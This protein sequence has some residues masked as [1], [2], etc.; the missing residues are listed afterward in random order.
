MSFICAIAFFVVVMAARAATLPNSKPGEIA[1]CFGM[2]VFAAMIFVLA[3]CELLK[4][5]GK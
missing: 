1:A 5:G 3:L 2:G 4:R